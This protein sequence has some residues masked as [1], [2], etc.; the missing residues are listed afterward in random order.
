LLQAN[1]T[2]KRAIV[3][4]KVPKVLLEPKFVCVVAAGGKPGEVE[5]PTSRELIPRRAGKLL[6]RMIRS[7]TGGE[8]RETSRLEHDSSDKT[9]SGKKNAKE[10][11]SQRGG[12]GDRIIE[13]FIQGRPG[14]TILWECNQEQG[15]K[16]T[17]K[18]ASW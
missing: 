13:S 18:R 2:E 7:I 11:Q 16:P 12:G 3:E 6:P 5:I 1:I 4:S 10:A 14:L 8:E 17:S 15:R 9:D